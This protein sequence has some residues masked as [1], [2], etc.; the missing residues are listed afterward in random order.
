MS[1]FFLST[2]V[3]VISYDY[4]I[5]NVMKLTFYECMESC[6]C[7]DSNLAGLFRV[8]VELVCKIG[9]VYN[10]EFLI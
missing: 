5:T 10:I 9:I 2:T 8:T 4:F 3:K 6:L 1:L 7:F